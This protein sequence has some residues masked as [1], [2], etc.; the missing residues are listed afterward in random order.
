MRFSAIAK[1]DIIAKIVSVAVSVLFGCAGWGY[2]SLILGACALPLST[3]IGAWVLCNWMPG[4]PRYAADTGTMLK[5]AMHT[6]G[7]FSF[8]YFARNTDNLL[9]GWRF[10]AHSLGFYKKAYD[11]FALSASQFVSAT[12]VV[13]VAALSRVRHD[14][15]QYHRYLL[16]SLAVMAFL[17]MGLAGDLTLIGKDL[18]RLLLGPGWG[19]AGQIFTFFAPG[20]GVMILYGTHGWIHLSIG[21]ADR[22][23]LWGIVEWVVTCL[24]FLV[25]LPWGPQGIAV[26]WC[27][28]FW[29]LTIPAMW[30]AG[31]P[32]GLGISPVLAAVWRY[33]AASLFA[34][35]T[36]R[37]F[38]SG[39]ASFAEAPGAFGA[40][41]RVLLVSMTFGC[42][43]LLAIVLLYRGLSPLRMLG[44]LLRE[45][46]SFVGV[47]QISATES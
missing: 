28:S 4:R 30:Y 46:V 18:I 20:I 45:M 42:L 25:G 37:L 7:R 43:Y 8:N 35:L 14:R 27:V 9:V 3:A 1:N 26:A 17:G 29:I 39:F 6:Y 38:F 2:W 47:E 40:A 31:R 22:W 21:R 44:D 23:L 16:G 15:A 19:P 24:L 32:I 34:G 12:T 36:C 33:L 13:A 11:L 41:I 10:G 5:Y